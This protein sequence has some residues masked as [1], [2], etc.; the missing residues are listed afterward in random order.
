[1]AMQYSCKNERRRTAIRELADPA[2]LNGIDYLEVAGDHKTL[3]VHFIHPL[4]EGMLTAENVAIAGGTRLRMIQ[5]QSVT[6]IDHRLIVRVAQIG[7]FST[8]TLQ[9]V[10]SPFVDDPPAGID[11]QLT[12]VSFSFWVDEVSEFDCQPPAEPLAKPEPLPAIDYLAKDYASFRRLM[13]DRLAVV[14]PDWQERNPSDVGVMLVELL[15]YSADHLSYYQDAVATEAYLES[16]RRRVSVRRHARLLDYFMHDGCN[17]RV[18]MVIKFGKLDE[19]ERETLAGLVLRGPDIRTQR[20]GTQFFS[21]SLIPAGVLTK[22]E[23]QSFDAAI[24]AGAQMFETLH[25]IALYP[26]LNQLCFYAWE[27]DRCRLPKGTTSATLM[28]LDGQ[29]DKTLEAG[30]VLVFQEIVGPLTGLEQDADLSHRH[31][32]RLTCVRSMVDPLTNQALVAVEWAVEDALPFDLVVSN[33]TAADQPIENITVAY[34]NV[35]LADAGRTRLP[36]EKLQ[37]QPGW[38]KRRPR[39]RERSL[40]RQG[41]VQ[42]EYRQWV[43]FDP[44]KPAAAA[45]QWALRDVRPAIALYE[46][47]LPNEQQTQGSS[48]GSGSRSGGAQW[49]A[50]ADLMMSDRFA[51]DFVVETEEDGQTFLRFG[52]GM[53]GKRPLAD[54]P[55]YALYRTGNGRQGNVGA[56]TIANIMLH[57][58][59]LEPEARAHLSRLQ[60]AIAQ[61][62]NPLAAAG[63]TEPEALDDV[64]RD[65]PQAFRVQQRAVTA[66]DYGAIAQQYAGVQRALATRRWTGSWYTMFIAIDRADGRVIDEPF[67]Q[68]LLK[69]LAEFQL[70]GHDIEIENPRFVPL[71]V[72]LTIQV[73]PD[74][75]RSA[76]KKA[77]LETFSNQVLPDGRS[78]FFVAEKFTFGQP[79]YLSEIVATAMQVTGVLSAQVTRF[80][81]WGEPSQQ[82]LEAGVIRCDRLEI[83]QLGG[84]SGSPEEGQLTLNLEGGR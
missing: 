57:G 45:M 82:A 44:A 29:L 64:R 32:V 74:Y 8:Y 19:S 14:T 25:D 28:D 35:V 79:V 17:A 69:F 10:E 5:I 78:G 70:A 71:D 36:A 37:E 38:E 2:L 41:Y 15:A 50:R 84:R 56:G 13:L 23:K 9:L 6:S 42:N 63:G 7:D 20:P 80:E 53:L 11:P 48:N 65:A 47:R 72:A 52:D 43:R 77:L 55:L 59:N 26:A 18:W 21:R 46:A 61:V 16:A 33:V 39:L 51:R 54:V 81:R 30:R 62:Y 1:M 4:S 27:D 34:G 58:Y 49:Q 22:A 24:R 83:I 68:G 67:K 75:F 3:E 60:G 40:T 12:A 66:E 76:V 31:V 73:K